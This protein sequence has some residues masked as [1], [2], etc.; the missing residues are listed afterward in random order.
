MNGRRVVLTGLGVVTS[1][2]ETVEEMWDK[3]CAGTSGIGPI[4]RWDAS[5]FPTRFGG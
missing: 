4:K 3:L 5:T 2:G 1:L